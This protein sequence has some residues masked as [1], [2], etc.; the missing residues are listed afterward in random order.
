MS[1]RE[2]ESAH[3]NREMKRNE[4]EKEVGWEGFHSCCSAGFPLIVDLAVLPVL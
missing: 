3:R 2:T 1:V 4:E